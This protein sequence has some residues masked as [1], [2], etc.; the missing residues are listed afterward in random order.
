MFM[1]IEKACPGQQ[2]P[3]SFGRKCGPRALVTKGTLRT[4][5]TCSIYDGKR[6]RE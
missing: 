3:D 6:K 1:A 5:R 2:D 4:M